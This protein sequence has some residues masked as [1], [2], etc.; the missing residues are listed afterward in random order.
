M[1]KKVNVINKTEKDLTV[2]VNDVGGDIQ[3]IIER[4]EAID[5]LSLSPGEIFK[6]N[7]I[8]YIV[9]EELDGN[10]TAVIRKE[11]LE[12]DMEFGS[13]SNWNTSKIKEFLNNAYL[14]E[15]EDAFGKDRIVEHTADLMSLDGLDDYGTSIDKVSLLTIDQYRKYR[16]LLSGNMDR[17]WWLATS[18]STPSGWNSRCVRCVCSDGCVNYNGC[19]CVRGVRPFFVLK[20]LNL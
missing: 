1:C 8:E 6:V 13:D 3:I 11:L 17:W 20:S 5:L 7:N 16:K 10:Q 9:L 15:I 18:D 2:T 19:G 12:D 14:H 4:K